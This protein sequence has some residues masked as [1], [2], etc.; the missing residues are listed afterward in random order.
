LWVL[1]LGAGAVFLT[2]SVIGGL[3]AVLITDEVK[4]RLTVFALLVAFIA[5]FDQGGG[6][7]VRLIEQSLTTRFI[8]DSIQSWII[9]LSLLALN[10][11]LLITDMSVWQRVGAVESEREVTR[12]LGRFAAMLLP[13]M[14]GII[15]IGIGF[16]TYIVPPEGATTAQAIIAFFSDS[17]ISIFL[18]AGLFAAL[19]TTADS[20]LIAAVQTTMVDLYF[21]K[22]LQKVNYKSQHLS[23]N[24]Q[25][26]MVR[27]SQIGILI[28]GIGTIFTGYVLFS[29]L[30]S[31]LDLIF[32][33]FGAQTAL[34]PSIFYGLADKA[35]PMDARAAIASLVIGGLS[36]I[37]CLLLALGGITL[38]DVSLGLWSPII[39]L[40]LSSITFLLLKKS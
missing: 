18:M 38:L 30:P 32:V 1:C 17:L 7:A 6:S 9:L 26:D 11:P 20:Y 27:S 5:L 29:I 4:Y 36:A 3:P 31:L 8:P 34:A 33:I 35:Q 40:S 28:L 39:V 19:L 10:L 37:V 13:W 23:I 16:S 14:S 24:E 2:Y 25:R 12:G 22:R 15:F 21:T